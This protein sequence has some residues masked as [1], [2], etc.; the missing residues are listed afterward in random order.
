MTD[1]GVLYMVWGSDDKIERALERSTKSLNAIHPE[2]PIEIVRLNAMDPIKGLLEKARMFERSP[3]RQTLF[4]DADTVVLDRLDFGFR[5]AQ[6]FGLACCICECPWARRYGGVQGETIEYNT[7]VLFFSRK[8]KP[9]FERWARLAPQINSS[10]VHLGPQGQ[11][12]IMPYNDQG[13]FALAVEGSNFSP[14]VLPLNWNLRPE[15][16][17][18]FFGPV[19]IWHDY[20]EVPAFFTEMRKYYLEPGSIIQYAAFQ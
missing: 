18:S 10:I 19:K 4:L 13:S 11:R 5:K 7:G 2:L 16:Q 9:V 8:A 20:R 6:Q 14:F 15:W 17:R 12:L 3:F 1:R